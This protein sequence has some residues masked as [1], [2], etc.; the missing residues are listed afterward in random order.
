MGISKAENLTSHGTLIVDSQTMQD[1]FENVKPGSSGML[2]ELSSKIYQPAQLLMGWQV[3]P[4]H[5]RLCPTELLTL[6]WA[7]WYLQN[8]INYE[9]YDKHISVTVN[10]W[11]MWMHTCNSGM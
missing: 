10:K 9:N 4:P 1:A 11:T 3:R 6:S 5:A 8:K 2:K 7:C